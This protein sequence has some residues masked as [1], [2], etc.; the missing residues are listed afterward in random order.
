[1]R[2]QDN[3][4]SVTWLAILLSLCAVEKI[5]AEDVTLSIL[6]ETIVLDR[7]EAYQ[8]IIGQWRAADGHFLAGR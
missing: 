4:W 5:V 7:S 1:M 6:P 3:S 8:A 2:W